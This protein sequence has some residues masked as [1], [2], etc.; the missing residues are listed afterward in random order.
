MAQSV[1][2]LD[3]DG[4]G[5]DSCTLVILQVK[6][7]R[8]CS[9][10]LAAKSPFFLKLFSNGMKESCQ[11]HAMIRIAD[12]EEKAFKE[13]L[14]F[15]Y[16]GKLAPVIEPTLLVDI[17]MAADKFE[18]VSCMEHCC[19]C[20]S[21][22]PM[23]PKS[24]VRCLDL[25]CS[26]SM[27]AALTKMAKKFLAQ[28]YKDFLSTEFQ[29]ELMRVPLAGIQAILSSNRPRTASEESIYD[30]VLRWARSQYPNSEE[31]DKI[32]SSRLLP[33][34]PLS[35]TDAIRIDHPSNIINFTINRDLCNNLFPLGTV[36]SVPFNCEGLA[37]F[38]SACCCKEK[39]QLQFF[40]LSINMIEGKGATWGPIDYK[41][42]VM[43]RRSLEFVTKHRHTTPPNTRQTVGCK[44]PWSELMADDSTFFIDGKLHVRVHVK[45]SQQA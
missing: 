14:H 23:T 32:L 20:L 24:A 1:D 5:I 12:S 37:F 34:V 2:Q 16:S 17:L 44:V 22:L 8:V 27:A 43:T 26:I 45:I 39:E 9:A 38:I 7:M 21:R 30:F 18:V 28:W 13:L 42:E 41:I 35:M 4:E 31:R 15:M 10:I 36:R 6:T 29:D 40:N 25:P 33:L 11:R 19:Q 3:D